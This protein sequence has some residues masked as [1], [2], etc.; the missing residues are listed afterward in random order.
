MQCY[1]SLFGCCFYLLSLSL[2]LS[3]RTFFPIQLVLGPN[4]GDGLQCLRMFDLEHRERVREDEED[5]TDRIDADKHTKLQDEHKSCWATAVQFHIGNHQSR[6]KWHDDD[7]DV[8]VV[9]MCTGGGNKYIYA[10]CIIASTN[11]SI[12]W[13]T[14]N[15]WRAHPQNHH[16]CTHCTQQ[17]AFHSTS[18]ARNVRVRCSPMQIKLVKRLSCAPEHCKRWRQH[19]KIIKIESNSYWISIYL[20][21]PAIVTVVSHSNIDIG[22]HHNAPLR[23]VCWMCARTREAGTSSSVINDIINRVPRSTANTGHWTC[24]R[25]SESK[26]DRMAVP[27]SD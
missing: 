23:D 7:D 4:D 24:G 18:T 8:D 15:V 5:E 20:H 2:S 1:S 6:N 25:E 9:E 16:A 27:Y 13:Q 3:L 22:Q 14:C 17:P 19:E 21:L 12:N 11:N 26:N 10:T